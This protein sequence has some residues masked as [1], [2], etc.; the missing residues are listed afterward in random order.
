MKTPILELA[1]VTEA[2]TPAFEEINDAFWALDAVVQLAVVSRVL[3]VPPIDAE[4]GDRYIIP[5]G[6]TGVW[7]NRT[8]K[9]AYFTLQGWRFRTPRPGW[10]AV[11][12]DENNTVY[13]FQQITW[14]PLFNFI[15]GPGITIEV[16]T[17]G[18]IIISATGSG[19]TLVDATPAAVENNYDPPDWN[20]GAGVNQLRITP[21]AGGSSITGLESSGIDE[22]DYVT[23]MNQSAV[24]SIDLP[25]DAAGSTAANRFYGPGGADF[26]IPP[27]ASV[28]I[29]KDLTLSRWRFV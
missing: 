13:V 24:D 26:S 5:S 22:G 7:A 16:D 28:R 20:G 18:Q 19:G 9:I 29:T 12:I 14:E 8:S 23:L 21:F 4:Q 3:T 10:I 15:E 25:H 2:D 27:L 1:E 11:V 6:A 17:G